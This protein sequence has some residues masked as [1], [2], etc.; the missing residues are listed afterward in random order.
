[1]AKT[2]RRLFKV[3]TEIEARNFKSW[4][5]LGPLRLAPIT[6]FF[7]A[8]SSGK[9]SILQLILLLK[10]TSAS[11]DRTQALELGDGRSLVD[12]GSFRD[13]TYGEE[14][15]DLEIGIR[16]DTA[17]S[18]EVLDPVTGSDVLFSA[19]DFSFETTIAPA[20]SGGME[21]V[22]FA[23][24][25]GDTFV[26]MDRARQAH[27]RDAEYQL[28]AIVRGHDDYLRRTPGRP[29]P[30]P[31]PIKCYGFPDEATGYYQNSGFIGD[32]ELA[33]DRQLTD[34]TFYL[35]PLRSNPLREY[36]W[37]G[38]HPEDVGESGERAVEALL[39]SRERGRTNARKFNALGRA[40]RRITVEEHVAEWL[41]ELRLVDDFRV[42]RL[43]DEADIYRVLVKKTASSREVFI[44]DVGFGVSQ[45]LPVLVLL[46]YV[47]EGSTVILEQPEIHLHP[48]VQAGLAD[49]LIEVSKVR[50]VQI[51]VE[52]HSEHL[53][54]RLQLRTADETTTPELFALYFCVNDQG[55]SR[56]DDLGLNIFGEIENWPSD[57]FGDPLGETAA[58]TR[59]AINRRRAAAV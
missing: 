44:T 17:N 47:P 30:L 37:K 48:A 28:S 26:A 42:Q 36:R 51:L 56:V 33:L 29:W 52:S 23:Y 32:L 31:S 18:V 19:S 43:S 49:I 39:A 14:A 16:W 4:R 9:T 12:L 8:N 7:G 50:R 34:R 15:T 35:G 10:Q 27:R 57:F 5:T 55:Q 3:F 59:A 20:S 25:A 6:G 58:M 1:M 21:V 53:L 46:A 45:I 40:M 2:G 38:T 22:R 41:K 11:T 24:T 13:L 54:R